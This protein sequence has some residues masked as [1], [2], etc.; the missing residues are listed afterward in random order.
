M[1]ENNNSVSYDVNGYDEVTAALRSLINS[2]AELAEGGKISFSELPEDG[3][4]AWYPLSGAVV[5]REMKSITG[6]IFQI[7]GYPFQVIFRVAGSNENRKAD[8]K[9]ALDTFGGGLEKQQIFQR[10][11]AAGNSRKY[12]ALH[13]RI[14]LQ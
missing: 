8:T 1:S 3:G 13:R 12:G 7:C 11:Q 6:N 10:L 9:E 4:K 14:S 2:Y 5:E